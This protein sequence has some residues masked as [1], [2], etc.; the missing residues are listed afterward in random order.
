M[1]RFSVSGTVE[2]NTKKGYTAASTAA[3]SPT[4]GENTRLPSMASTTHASAPT[5][6]SASWP[7]RR[8][9]PNTRYTAAR[10]SGVNGGRV[11]YGPSSVWGGSSS[12]TNS[13]R[14]TRLTA[15]SWY[16]CASDDS[17]NAPAPEVQMYAPRTARA[18]TNS[19][20]HAARHLVSEWNVMRRA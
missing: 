20:R 13:C 8:C 17:A 19:A 12:D 10:N 6:A 16:V 14:V 1:A 15:M 3:V 2:R 5:T 18:R 11:A 7:A 4:T 9:V